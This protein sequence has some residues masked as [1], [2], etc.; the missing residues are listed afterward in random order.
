MS[1][2]KTRRDRDQ[3]VH[4]SSDSHSEIDEFEL[5][6]DEA[7]TTPILQ[8]PEELDEL[9]FDPTSQSGNHFSSGV[10][11]A[12][13]EAVRAKFKRPLS[14]LETPALALADGVDEPSQKASALMGSRSSRPKSLDD[15]IPDLT[16]APD[17]GAVQSAESIAARSVVVPTGD[18]FEIELLPPPEASR[19]SN[20][21]AVSASKEPTSTS[22]SVCLDDIDDALGGF[23]TSFDPQTLFAQESGTSN[24]QGADISLAGSSGEQE[25]RWPHMMPL[26]IDIN[27]LEEALLLQQSGYGSPPD[28]L[29]LKPSYSLTVFLANRALPER[30]RLARQVVDELVLRR[31]C[32]LGKLAEIHRENLEQKPRFSPLYE[33]QER[34]NLILN[35]LLAEVEIMDR[36]SSELMAQLEVR[37]NAGRDRLSSKQKIASSHANEMTLL[38]QTAAR[39]EAQRT[40]LS[41]ERRN[42]V[43]TL[44]ES[45]DLPVE[46]VRKYHE[47]EKEITQLAGEARKKARQQSIS[48][49]G[50]LDAARVAMAELQTLLA[51]KA[52]LHFAYA[53]D[54]SLKLQEVDKARRSYQEAAGATG[55]ALV[56][57]RGEV[58]IAGEVREELLDLE[59]Q[60]EQEGLKVALLENVRIVRDISSFRQGVYLGG[61]FLG[62]FLM[63]LIWAILR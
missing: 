39:V 3:R 33:Q 9:E 27:Q 15:L 5:N 46:L 2:D 55:T 50:L 49:E 24:A 57:L 38:N 42:L 40:R 25:V 52:A 16:L 61:T 8:A 29:W 47:Q 17:I 6:L 45:A 7:T 4:S 28:K 41:I 13:D 35:A 30:L 14:Q 63:C 43:G 59:E 18:L 23:D 54:L 58:P 20:L 53:G 10:D 22:A 56:Q 37:V 32:C 62:V 36:S 26:Q 11:D 1:G 44:D 60:L 12:T 19:E 21:S 31:D 51:E 48:Y 34:K